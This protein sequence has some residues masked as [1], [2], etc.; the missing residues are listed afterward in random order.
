MDSNNSLSSTEQNLRDRRRDERISYRSAGR[1]YPQNPTHGDPV[2]VWTNDVSVSGAALLSHEEIAWD[3]FYLELILPKFAGKALECEV[4]GKHTQKNSQ[5]SRRAD[6]IVY[7]TR[8]RF[9][10]IVPRD[11]VRPDRRDEATRPIEPPSD[12]A[13]E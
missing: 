11:D 12:E 13:A 7:V 2:K 5:F 1:V 6:D 10:Q 4:V 8:V 3:N 9:H